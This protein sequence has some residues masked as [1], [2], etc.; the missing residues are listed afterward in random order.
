MHPKSGH[1]DGLSSIFAARVNWNWCGQVCLTP[2]TTSVN[3][4]PNVGAAVMVKYLSAAALMLEIDESAAGY[5]AKFIYRKR[6][7]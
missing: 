4:S 2:Y 1:V 7:V 6:R 5:R 3:E